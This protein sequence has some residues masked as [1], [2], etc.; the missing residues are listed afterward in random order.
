M[1]DEKKENNGQLRDL[2]KELKFAKKED[3]SR[4]LQLEDGIEK[5]VTANNLIDE[6][7]SQHT[8][9]EQELKD[10]KAGIKEAEKKKEDLNDTFEFAWLENR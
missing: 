5:L 9:V 4:A 2:K 1:K 6:K 3:S 10:L 7:L 8:A